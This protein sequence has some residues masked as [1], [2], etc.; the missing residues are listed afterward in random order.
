MGVSVKVWSYDSETHL[1]KPGLLAPRMVCGT[2]AAR[3]D[4]K[5]TFV[6]PELEV[7]ET[8]DRD[9]QETI[10]FKGIGTR[11]RGLDRLEERLSDDGTI[12]VGHN[13]AYDLGVAVANRPR[14]IVPVFMK[15]EKG[16]V[17]DTMIRQQLIDIAT[18]EMKFFEDED[19]D[20]IKTTYTLADLSYRLLKK[21]LKKED[22]WRLKY[23]LLDGV[24]LLEWPE[25]ARKYAIDDAVTTLEVWEK[26]E[27][28]AGVGATCEGIPNSVEQHQAAW[29][30]H[31]M[32]MWGVRTDGEMVA[33]LRESL[34]AELAEKMIALRPTGLFKIAPARINRK[35]EHVPEKVSK[36]M[37][38]IHQRVAEAYTRKA[39][40]EANAQGKE[41]D[42]EHAVPLTESGKNIAADK[43]TLKESG[44][45]DLAALAEAGAVS[46]L[47]DT[48]VP[49]LESG[50]R[51][52]ITP[53]YNVL[54]ETG[55]TSCS[56]PNIQNPP[57]KGGVRECFVARPGYVYAFSDYDTLELRSLAQVCLDMIGRSEMAEALRRGEDLHLS[58]AAEMMGITLA[59]AKARFDAGDAEVKEYRQQAK[60]ANFGFPGGM[61]A[62]SF[63][64]Y[65]EGYGIF[66]TV[67]QAEEIHETWFGKW[68]EMSPYFA[69]IKELT[70]SGQPIVQVR[71]G[72]V[73][74]GASFCAAANGFFQGLAA[75]GAKE[76][77]WLVAKECYVDK[78]S[79]LYGCRP[80]FFIH[81]ELG[82]EIPFTNF[83]PERSAAAAERLSVV[84]IEAMKR[85]I[86]D[87]PISCKPVMVRRWFKG[88]EQV[89]VD[90]DGRPTLV[91]CKPVTVEK[92]GKKKTT[93]MADL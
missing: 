26:Q 61:A 72:R 21:W 83:G 8:F 25:D 87:V 27:V 53:R 78:T 34:S 11:E 15:Y 88:A 42:L 23:A 65:A 56:K 5:T 33:K 73:R 82:L 31:L 89:K 47:L 92:D 32:S 69:L 48:Y 43:K 45:K 6:V 58:L 24:P 10:V 9:Y 81:D 50:T 55:R 51:V 46:K 35:K 17:H 68:T 3:L 76:A 19:G 38:A 1:I 41:P 63:R 44:D 57:R 13:T 75:D 40:E 62:Q 22:T 49:V 70:E 93:W 20:Q 85:W 37:A 86:P 30:L 29:A 18:G 66:L 79:P 60:P 54:V 7:A 64:E 28:I 67:E 4:Y 12:I 74:G 71:S 59:D 16:L 91:P 14:L 2:W 80:V 39:I 77:C 52:P 36:N 84:M 90:I